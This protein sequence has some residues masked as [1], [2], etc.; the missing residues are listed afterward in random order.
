MKIATVL[1]SVLVACL[2]AS[3]GHARASYSSY[4]EVP[5]VSSLQSI[6]QTGNTT[7]NRIAAPNVP[8]NDH[9]GLLMLAGST[10]AVWM[11]YKRKK[12]ANAI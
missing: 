1:I 4:H 7:Q 3:F 8:I 2:S 6:N 12:H 10:A 11:M 5:M 9:L